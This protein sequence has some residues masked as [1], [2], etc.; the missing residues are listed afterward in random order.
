MELPSTYSIPL[1]NP[2][3][4]VTCGASFHL[5]HP[6]LQPDCLCH[7]W[8]TVASGASFQLPLTASISTTR[9]SLSHVQHRSKWSFLP[10]TASISTTRLSLSHVEHRSKW[11]FPPLLPV[12]IIRCVAKITPVEKHHAPV[13]SPTVILISFCLFGPVLH[14]LC[15]QWTRSQIYM[16]RIVGW[17]KDGG[18]TDV[19]KECPAVESNTPASNPH[20]PPDQ[21]TCIQSNTPVNTPASNLHSPPDQYTCIQSNTPVKYTSQQSSPTARSIYVHTIKYT[22]QYTSQQSSLTARSIYVH[23]IKYTSQ[24]HQSIHQPA[25]F[26][27]RQI[28]IRA[29]NQIH[30]SNTPVNTPASNL[31]SPPDQYT[32]IQ[33]NTPVKYTSQQSS[34]T[35]RSIYVHTIKYTSQYTSQQSSLTARSIYVHTIKYTSQIHQSIHQPAI[36]THRQINIRAYNQIHQSNTPASNLHPPPDQYTCIQSNT[37][38]NTPASNLHSPPD[39]YTCIQSNTPVKYTSQYTSQQSSLTARSIYVHTIK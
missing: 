27:H 39:Q 3:V 22:S 14:D 8:S 31:H 2:T 17:W 28:N 16:V 15:Y 32:C 26:T 34:P 18:M 35:A 25:I 33:S 10:L 38:V 9:L 1:Y 20:S 6:S 13:T 4:S 12:S 11:S 5:Q 21:Y 29:Y 24:I 7:M 36:F 23:T 37:P 19:A 30:Q